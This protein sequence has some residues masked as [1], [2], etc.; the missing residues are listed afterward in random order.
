MRDRLSFK[1][2]Y[3]CIS[4][5]N[6]AKSKTKQNKQTKPTLALSRKRINLATT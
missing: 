4:I 6:Q 3:I 5:C 1:E 2:K